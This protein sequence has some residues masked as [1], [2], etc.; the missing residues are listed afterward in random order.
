MEVLESWNSITVLGA[1]HGVQ[2][3]VDL[4]LG[5]AENALAASEKLN[6]VYETA[7]VGLLEI[8]EEV[9]IEDRNR[10]EWIGGYA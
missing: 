8:G 5:K 4:V 3:I 10:Q 2:S 1:I 9:G 6:R 7:L